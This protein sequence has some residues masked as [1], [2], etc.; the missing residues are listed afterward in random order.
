MVVPLQYKFETG[1]SE[2]YRPPTLPW[3]LFDA[4]FKDKRDNVPPFTPI[5][6]SNAKKCQSSGELMNPFLGIIGGC[7]AQYVYPLMS[8]IKSQCFQVLVIHLR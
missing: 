6:L 3:Y 4:H 5:S 1:K 8:S 2:L 7:K